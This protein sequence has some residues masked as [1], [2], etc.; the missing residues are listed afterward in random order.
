MIMTHQKMHDIFNK[1]Y[2]GLIK[3]EERTDVINP[4]Y[5]EC[6]YDLTERSKRMRMAELGIM[7]GMSTIS[8][9][10]SLRNRGGSLLSIDI[11]IRGKTLEAVGRSGMD[12]MWSPHEAD[13]VKFGESLDPDEKFD[14]IYVDS[15]HT[16]EHCRKEIEVWYPHLQEGGM[17]AFHDI[18][19][20]QGGEIFRAI[21]E[22]VVGHPEVKF[23]PYRQD[24]GIIFR[25]EKVRLELEPGCRCGGVIFEVGGFN[26]L[27]K[28]TAYRCEVCSSIIS[29]TSGYRKKS[30]PP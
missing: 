8:F 25:G 14:L 28:S 24:I 20:G 5:V 10:Y 29:L 11:D 12:F 9:L 30:I 17:M 7:Y 1:S 16:Y 26:P 27:D 4:E 18:S 6:L 23:S 19:A 3:D 15:N 13:S 22:F 21:S 2:L